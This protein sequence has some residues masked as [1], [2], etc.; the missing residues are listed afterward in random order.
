LTYIDSSS[1]A[2]QKSHN[3]FE[4]NY[5]I[6]NKKA[7]FYAMRKYYKLYGEDPFDY[8]PLT[9]HISGGLEDAE[10]GEFLDRYNMLNEE[11]AKNKAVD[12][13]NIWIVKPGEV[14]NRGRGITVCATLDEIKIRLKSKEKNSDG[15]LRTYILQKYIEKPLLYQKRKFDIRH[16]MLMTCVN[17]CIKGYWYQEGYIRT[18]STEYNIRNCKD[19]YTHLTNDAIQKNSADYG[20]Y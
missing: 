3:H 15:S 16:Y 5:Y 18:T 19:L 12:L 8:I 11:R 4:C 6:G 7:L 13:K 20:K 1:T 9:Y 17:G 14:T 10:F 2:D